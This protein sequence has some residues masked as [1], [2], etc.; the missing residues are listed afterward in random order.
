[1][2]WSQNFSVSKRET[3]SGRRESGMLEVTAFIEIV[4]WKDCPSTLLSMLLYTHILIPSLHVVSP[5]CETFH[6]RGWLARQAYKYK[7]FILYL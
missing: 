1:M 5:T 6:A 2:D 4:E 3:E 7:L